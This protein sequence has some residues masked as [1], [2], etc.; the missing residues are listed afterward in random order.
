MLKYILKEIRVKQ[1][2]KNL[3]IFVPAFFLWEKLDITVY[4]NLIYAFFLFSFVAS[5]V[6]ILNDI[7][8]VNIDRQ[9]PKKKNRPLASGKISIKLAIFLMLLFLIIGL[10]WAYLINKYLF[11]LLAVYYIINVLYSVSLKHKV[12]IDIILIS[13]M[14]YMRILAGAII[15]GVDPSYWIFLMV[16]FGAM[17]LI[18]WKRYAELCSNRD[19]KRKVIEFYSK[20]LLSIIFSISIIITLVSYIFYTFNKGQYMYFTI[21]LVLYILLRYTYLV[22]EENKWEEPEITLLKDPGILLSFV[23]LFAVYYFVLYNN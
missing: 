19:E 17:F 9:H 2:V 18:S 12:I 23:F 14:Y 6:Y 16:F 20:L 10:G 22:L 21:I 13:F 4:I 1:W 7:L 5:S 3:L 8:D 11:V 15:I